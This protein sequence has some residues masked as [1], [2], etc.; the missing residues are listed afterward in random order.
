MT[1]P[2]KQENV[3]KMKC[4]WSPCNSLAKDEI[5]LYYTKTKERRKVLIC[6]KHY[7]DLMYRSGY[8]TSESAFIQEKSIRLESHS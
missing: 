5:H 4:E 7:P 3:R 6:T 8:D 2:R 1:T